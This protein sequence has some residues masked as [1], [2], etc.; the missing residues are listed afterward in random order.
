M[1]GGSPL[2]QL[3]EADAD[4]PDVRPPVVLHG[5]QVAAQDHLGGVVAR[6]DGQGQ[7]QGQA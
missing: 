7:S 5:A 1:E 3:D 4:R 2:C 6:S